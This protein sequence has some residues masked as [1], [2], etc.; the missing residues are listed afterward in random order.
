LGGHNRVALTDHEIIIVPRVGNLARI[1]PSQTTVEMTMNKYCRICWNTR[2]W[3]QPTG[4]AASLETGKSYVREN[5]FG[6]EEWLFNFSWTQPLSREPNRQVKYGFLQPIGKYRSAYEGETFDV[7]VYTVGPDRERIAVATIRN[8]HVPRLPELK[9]AL[10]LIRR[11][12]WLREMEDDL[13]DL[14]ISAS[15]LNGPA[16]HL[17]NVRF[18]PADVTFFDPRILVPRTHKLYRI[19]RYQPID[20]ENDFPGDESAVRRTDL[21]RRASRR[22]SEEER[23]RAAI[24]GTTY[25]PRHVILQNALYDH[26][27]EVYGRDAVQY[28]RSFVDLGVEKDGRATYFEIKIAPTAKGCI[29]DALGQLLEYGIYPDSLRATKLVIVGDGAPT[30]DDRRYLEYLRRKFFLPIHYR[31][32][33]WGRR[34][35]SEEL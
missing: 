9:I 35:L 2:Y 24:E 4:E 6:H 28:E 15:K 10:R 20:W 5:G 7:L 30:N 29:R 27:C 13:S 18:D 26:L 25:S 8:L 12:G 11:N 16:T 14:G 22:R 17:I 1:F 23:R 32:W 33:V 19:N 3:R 34:E 31:Q 21:P